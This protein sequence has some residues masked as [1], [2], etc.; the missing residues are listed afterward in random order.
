MKTAT[1]TLT[2]R[3]E[4]AHFLPCHGGKCRRTHGHNYR[5]DVT[6]RGPVAPMALGASNAREGMTLEFD[7]VKAVFGERVHSLMDHQT[8]NDIIPKEFNPPTTENV[9]YYIFSVL[10]PV[11]PYLKRVRVWET[12][13][14]NAYVTVEDFVQYQT[15]EGWKWQERQ[16]AAAA[17]TF[18]ASEIQMQQ[19]P[20][21]ESSL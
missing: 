14:S 2:F 13:R 21:E 4:A 5:V 7:D 8:I 15:S 17:Q 10:Y 3:F 19:Q 16:A 1:M 9:A 12:E 11:V 20:A 18:L 6:M